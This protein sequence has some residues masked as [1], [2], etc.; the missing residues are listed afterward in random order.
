M[1]YHSK[2]CKL[3]KKQI[4]ETDGNV[5]GDD[6]DANHMYQQ[7]LWCQLPKPPT[8]W[9]TNLTI[10]LSEEEAK[11][12]KERIILSDSDSLWSFSLKHIPDEAKTFSNI[13]D[14]LSVE[15]LPHKLKELV[16]LSVDFNTIMQ[17]ALIRY[18]FLIQLSRENGRVKSFN[19]F[20]KLFERNQKF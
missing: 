17:G 13:T 3:K 6:K 20:G 19:P 5:P 4:A 7:H 11:F 1:K 15:E 9:K 2:N 18:N 8:D 14:F 10:D 12:L 16:K